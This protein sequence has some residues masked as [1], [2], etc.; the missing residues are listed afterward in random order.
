MTETLLAC[1]LPAFKRAFARESVFFHP[2]R[3]GVFDTFYPL[4]THSVAPSR[5][6]GR[7]HRLCCFAARA[8]FLLTKGFANGKNCVH[9]KAF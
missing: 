3:L 1:K 9:S 2:W 8:R 5:R 6:P 4:L 7:L